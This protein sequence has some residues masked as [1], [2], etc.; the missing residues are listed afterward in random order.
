MTPYEHKEFEELEFKKS[1]E[2]AEEWHPKLSASR[3]KLSSVLK[4]MDSFKLCQ[5]NIPLIIKLVE[6]P[7]YNTSKLFGGA[8]DLFTHD[9]IHV[10]LGRGLLVK[11]EAFV[12]GYT[13]GST[14]NMKRWKRN[15]FMFVS[16]YLYPEGYK[17]REEERF[18]F[19]AGVMAGSLCPI[20]LSQINFKKY[21]NRQIKTIRKE[22]GVD[23]D[24][25]EQYYSIEKKCF[26]V[27]ESQRL[28]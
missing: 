10:V 21:L 19:N 16:K 17:F 25:L 18:V 20:N 6:N 28:L 23:V 15:L 5:E 1:Q 14:K 9:C 13:M 8:V 3:R 26:N 24:F 22:I 7:N 4:E 2:A 11:D 12:I 27:I